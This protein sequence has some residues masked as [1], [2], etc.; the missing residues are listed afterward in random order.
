MGTARAESRNRRR[1]N[2]IATLF[3]LHQATVERG[4][5]T[6]VRQA[7]GSE[8]INVAVGRRLLGPARG[9]SADHTSSDG[10]VD[11][12]D[13]KARTTTVKDADLI[14]VDNVARS[15]VL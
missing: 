8:R 12:G 14:A 4:A 9:W 10:A 7:L 3:D 1:A 2:S 5:A 11:L 13:Q 15:G 6:L